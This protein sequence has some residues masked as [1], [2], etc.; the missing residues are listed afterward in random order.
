MKKL[1]TAIAFLAIILTATSA[2]IAQAPDFAITQKHPRLLMPAGGEK[3]VKEKIKANE[4]LART[5]KAI[6]ADCKR[7]SE[8]PLEQFEPNDQLFLKTARTVLKRVYFMAYA[9]R[10]TGNK[11]YARRAVDEMLNA[12]RFKTWHPSHFLGVAEMTLALS[13]GYD[14]LLPELSKAERDT[15]LTAIVEKGLN[16]SLAETMSDP[17]YM[18]WQKKKNNWNAVCNTGMAYGAIVTY[19]LNPERSK[20]IIDRA[21]K[22]VRD[23]ALAEYLP[24]GNYPEGYTY[25]SYGTAYALLLNDALEALYGTSFGLTDNKGFMRTP[26]YIQ[27]LTAQNMEYFAYSDCGTNRSLSFPMFWFDARLNDP[28]LMYGELDRLHTM[29]R[30]CVKDKKIFD[31]R[32]LPAVMLW[33]SPNVF[34]NVETPKENLY[35]AHGPTPVAIM[36]NHRGGD[37]ELY[38]GVK[39]GMSSLNHGHM[40]Q[41]AFVINRGATPWITDIGVQDYYSVEKFGITLGDRSQTGRRWDV[42]RFGKDIHNI[43]TFNGASQIVTNKA[44]IVASGSHEDFTYSVVNLSAVDSLTVASHLRGVAIAGDSCVM[45]R[46]EIANRDIFNEARWAALT[47]AEVE[48]TGKNSLVLSRGDRHM[49]MFVEGGDV[50]LRTWSTEPRNAFDEPNPGTRMIGFTTMLNPGEKRAINVYFI[51]GRHFSLPA[52]CK[53][54]NPIADWGK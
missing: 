22:R 4:F 46:D 28:S 3:I 16:E 27:Q 23:V 25:W 14:W 42:L 8:E 47:P 18:H 39:G 38:V 2:A 6:L 49:T 52:N 15:I 43:L 44:E 35:V 10:M 40:D 19:E 51:P 17:S 45:V 41:G 33:A 1:L 9:Y 11:K 26:Y 29:E 24:D 20:F 5:H 32:F 7:M 53:K 30:N 50:A 12:C 13:I 36:R 21:V 31:V 34:K 37:D 54:I 48:I